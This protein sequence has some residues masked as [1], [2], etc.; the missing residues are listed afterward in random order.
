MDEFWVVLLILA[1]FGVTLGGWAWLGSRV[2]RRGAPSG[3]VM[4][5]FDEIWH[6]AAHRSRF[7][8][9]AEDERMAPR[10]SPDDK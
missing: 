9:E 2:R 6:P 5:V 1:N 4:G 8:I 3:S 10:A 7:V